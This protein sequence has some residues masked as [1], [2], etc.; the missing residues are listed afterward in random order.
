MSPNAGR[1]P[2]ALKLSREEVFDWGSALTDYKYVENL[3]RD[4]TA[5]KDYLKNP[6]HNCYDKEI[7]L[8]EMIAE[9]IVFFN[10]NYE[11]MKE[12]TRSLRNICRNKERAIATKAA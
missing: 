5:I 2:K 6:K 8:N 10:R 3:N 11:L 9:D 4:R 7:F 1:F 12:E